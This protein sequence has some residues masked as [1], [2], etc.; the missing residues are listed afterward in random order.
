[1]RSGGRGAFEHDLGE[2]AERLEVGD[3]ER[4]DRDPHDRGRVDPRRDPAEVLLLATDADRVLDDVEAAL[5]EPGV[6][7]ARVRSGRE[8]LAAVQ[9]LAP[10]L[11]VLDLQIGNMGGVATCLELRNEESFGRL[12]EQKVLILLDRVADVFLAR[13]SGAD[14]WIIKP[15]DPLRL[16]RAAEAVLRGDE[17][18]DGPSAPVMAPSEPDAAAAG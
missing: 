7:I 10:D 17:Y 14:G 3:L 1:V 13:R 5:A 15:L 18:A 9:E 11:V 4:E 8:V 16:R 2:R 12:E 6:T